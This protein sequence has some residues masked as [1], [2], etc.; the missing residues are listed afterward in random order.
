MN[1]KYFD[2]KDIKK[3][4]C[5]KITSIF[6]ALKNNFGIII[7]YN[8]KLFNLLKKCLINFVIIILETYLYIFIV[9]KP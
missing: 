8:C 2:N 3:D 4:T 7:I 1:R 6:F 5:V 9:F